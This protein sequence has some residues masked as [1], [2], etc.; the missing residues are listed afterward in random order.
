MFL[1]LLLSILLV[2][3]LFINLPYNNKIKC[4][5]FFTLLLLLE[6]IFPFGSFFRHT[7]ITFNENKKGKT[8]T[9]KKKQREREK[10]IKGQQETVNKLKTIILF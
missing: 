9:A 6:G 8:T 2:I 10:D 1:S 4:Y 7:F 5:L 3:F